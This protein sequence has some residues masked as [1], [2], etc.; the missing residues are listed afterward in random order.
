LFILEHL[1]KY[2]FAALPTIL[3]LICWVFIFP[4]TLLIKRDP[5]IIVVFSRPGPA[6]ADNS[7]Y[8][9][10]YS[11][12]IKSK[13]IN[14][15]FFTQDITIQRAII[16]AGG[17]A[18]IH[19]SFKSILLLIK[20]G[21]I[22]TDNADWSNYGVYAI[23]QGSKIIQTWHGAPIKHI[24]VDLYKKRLDNT[25]SCIRPFLDIQKRILG[26][27]P[28][29]DIVVSTSKIF[30]DNAF[31]K[32]FRAKFF[33]TT[34]YPRN[35]ILLDCPCLNSKSQNFININIDQRAIDKAIEK[36][37]KGGKICMY[38]PTFRKDMHSPFDKEMNLERLS[39][40][41]LQHNILIVIKLHPLMNG[42]YNISRY[43]NLIEYSPI[44][45]VYPL[46]R[47]CDILIT[48]YSSIFFDFLLLDRPVIF[49]P[50]DLDDYLKNDRDMYFDYHSMTPGPKCFSYDELEQNLELLI[51]PDYIDHFADFRKKVTTFTHDHI[52]NNAHQR[53]YDAVM[54]L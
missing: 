39:G 43:P 42:L 22:V 9:F 19:P 20:C 49:F 16:N 35:D 34:G 7:K 8:F 25:P 53:L 37:S 11:H 1:K 3:A 50:Y 13:D 40:F 31:M 26:R 28:L 17:K 51:K 45:D 12:F 29:Y 24:E 23:S 30:I 46:M 47:L 27:Y 32:C 41:A 54:S 44:A 18:L 52:D 2:I 21:K 4:F 33:L 15:V 6:F 36:Q 38:V 14:L 10:I 48:D 5:R